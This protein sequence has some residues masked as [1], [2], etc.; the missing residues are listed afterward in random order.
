M[1]RALGFLVGTALTL[2]GG[3]SVQA[4]PPGGGRGGPGGPGGPGG[5]LGGM[6]GGGMM[7]GMGGGGAMQLLGMDPVVE[8]LK[9][10]ADQKEDLEELRG[11][12]QAK[13]RELMPG[14]P[15]AGG[16]GAGGPGGR[17]QGQPG[18]RAQGG[19]RG[20]GGGGRGDAQPPGRGG[21][22]GLMGAFDPE[23]LQEMARKMREMAEEVEE[24]VADILAPD[25]LDR[26]IGLIIQR[27]EIQ[28]V[29]SRLVADR[30]SITDQQK[31]QLETIQEDAQTK[32]QESVREAMVNFGGGGGGGFGGEGMRERMQ[33][34]R[35]NMEKMQKEVATEM[36]SV[37]TAE[38][39]KTMEQL[40]GA[41]FDFPEPRGWQG[42]GGR[43]PGGPGG[44]EAQ[45]GR[46]GGQGAEGAGRRGGGGGRPGRG[47]T[48]T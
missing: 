47:G 4:Q 6:M 9:L 5:M 25:Q 30:L 48:E 41:K 7:R 46:R 32:M 8:E 20:Q 24:E 15:G 13:M 2:S 3:W 22:G 11:K 42:A 26:L 29:M 10:D 35:E 17:G 14:R 12:F 36:E 31:K 23:A 38:Q 34:M 33:E 45:G 37:L 16:P 19:G 1:K 21:P 40:R 39:K 28:S 43:G 44:A 18:G 27:S